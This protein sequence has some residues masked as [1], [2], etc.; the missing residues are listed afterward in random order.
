MKTSHL[1]AVLAACITASPVLAQTADRITVTASV[2]HAD[3]DLSREA[4]RRTLEARI[5]HAAVDVCGDASSADLRG[6]N[7]VRRCRE[8]AAE[9]AAA[10]VRRTLAARGAGTVLALGE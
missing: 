1:L 6:G 9:L 4:G 8:D 10:Q 3:L 7:E 5:R 2:R